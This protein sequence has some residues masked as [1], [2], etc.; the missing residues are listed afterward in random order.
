MVGKEYDDVGT[1][2][3]SLRRTKGADFSPGCCRDTAPLRGNVLIGQPSGGCIHRHG[4]RRAD[5]SQGPG[6]VL[7]EWASRTQGA[8]R[9]P[10]C[11]NGWAPVPR[12]FIWPYDK[13]HTLL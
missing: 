6:D 11:L 12:L 13:G 4:Q 3:P 10:P 9:H 7:A 8:L 1:Q 2:L 5:V